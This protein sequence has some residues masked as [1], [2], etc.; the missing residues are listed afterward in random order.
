MSSEKKYRNHPN[1]KCRKFLLH[2]LFLTLL[3]F[4]SINA[5]SQ[6]DSIPFL[7]E[8]YR[9]TEAYSVTQTKDSVSIDTIKSFLSH[10]TD[11]FLLYVKNTDTLFFRLQQEDSIILAGLTVKIPNPGFPSVKRKDAEFFTGKFLHQDNYGKGAL[12]KEYITDSFEERKKMYFFFHISLPY[13]QMELQ[14]YGYDANPFTQ[15]DPVI[16]AIKKGNAGN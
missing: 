9:I 8:M 4:I 1:V 16:N 6:T 3:I 7:I 12:M 10:D 11:L 14:I 15:N 5:K 2:S 13:E